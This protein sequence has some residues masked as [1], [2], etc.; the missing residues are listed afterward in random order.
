MC[1]IST[2]IKPLAKYKNQLFPR[3]LIFFFQNY[4]LFENLAHTHPNYTLQRAFENGSHIT[5][6]KYYAANAVHKP[7]LIENIQINN[8]EGKTTLGTHISTLHTCTQ[9]KATRQQENNYLF[10]NNCLS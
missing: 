10:L 1:T 8:D 5:R 7:K 2:P 3:D 4:F 6:K 9:I